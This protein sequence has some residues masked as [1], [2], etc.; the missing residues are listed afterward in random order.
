MEDTLLLG[1]TQSS[2]SPVCKMFLPNSRNLG[3]VLIWGANGIK[4]MTDGHKMSQCSIQPGL[5]KSE[6]IVRGQWTLL[7]GCI[8][9]L[10]SL[11]NLD[12]ICSVPSHSHALHPSA[13][14]HMLQALCTALNPL[15]SPPAFSPGPLGP[16]ACAHTLDIGQPV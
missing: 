15:A 7:S 8:H 1:A 13:L 11:L 5:C 6:K 14:P 12:H 2:V 4:G 9:S 10:S 3:L 16:S